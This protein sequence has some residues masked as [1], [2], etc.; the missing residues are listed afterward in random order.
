MALLRMNSEVSVLTMLSF[1]HGVS[2]TYFATKKHF[3]GSREAEKLYGPAAF[4]I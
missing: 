3:M 4:D 2:V 1:P